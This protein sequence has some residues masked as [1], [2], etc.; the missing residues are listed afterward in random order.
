MIPCEYCVRIAN[1]MVMGY[2]GVRF[3]GRKVVGW[4]P[5]CSVCAF[6]TRKVCANTLLGVPDIRP[7]DRTAKGIQ[8][9]R[10]ES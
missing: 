6:R 7:L 9:Q 5:I 8:M 4:I 1:K 3:D 10:S 2:I